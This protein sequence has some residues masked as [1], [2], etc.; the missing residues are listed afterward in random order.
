MTTTTTTT[1]ADKLRREMQQSATFSKEEFINV[2]SNVIKKCG[3]AAF[4]CG[5][6][7]EKTSLGAPCFTLHQREEQIAADYARSE[8]FYVTY[9]HNSYGVR[10]MLI[11]L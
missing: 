7:I 4:Y 8:G 10:I 5:Y 2:I 1:A 9:K 6:H 3:R 11:T